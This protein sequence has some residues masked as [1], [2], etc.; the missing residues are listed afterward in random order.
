M[1]IQPSVTRYAALRKLLALSPATVAVTCSDISAVPESFYRADDPWPAYQ[2]LTYARS[3]GLPGLY[4]TWLWRALH[5]HSQCDPALDGARTAIISALV[6]YAAGN[7]SLKLCAMVNNRPAFDRCLFHLRTWYAGLGP[8]GQKFTERLQQLTKALNAGPEHW[9]QALNRF[10]QVCDKELARAA[11]LAERMQTSELGRIKIAHARRRVNDIYNEQVA[12]RQLP[13][14]ALEFI[15]HIVLPSLQYLLINESEQAPDWSFWLQVLRLIV[16]TVNPDKPPEDRQAFFNKGPALLSQLE[17]KAV[18]KAF[19][20]HVYHDYLDELSALIIS[21]LKGHEVDTITAPKRHISAELKSLSQLQS[22]AAKHHFCNGDW[23]EFDDGISLIRCQ[24]LMQVPNTDTLLFVNRSGH[25]VLQKTIAQMSVCFDAGIAQPI[26][27]TPGLSTALTTVAARME[28]MQEHLLTQARA[29]QTERQN[30]KQQQ[31][32]QQQAKNRLLQTRHEAE[33][34]ARQE[35]RRLALEH[36]AQQRAIKE[37]QA[38]QA[39][40][41]HEQQMRDTLDK[42]TLGTWA[43]L[44]LDNGKPVRCKLA[45]SMRSSNKYIFVDRVG[46]KI[47]ELLYDDLLGFLQRGEATFYQPEQPFESRLETIVRGLRRTE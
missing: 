25:K 21:L 17:T 43:D 2:Q 6:D 19:A 14:S 22:G 12:Q 46:Q 47:A 29:A 36:D 5:E 40:Q 10:N 27:T 28:N 42:L 3:A 45:V 33:L 30:L 23:L 7:E 31:Q 9:A 20:Q 13:E 41:A 1:A 4:A 35:A 18:S 26:P 8:T 38:S 24:F 44:P 34:K 16:W 32:A 11:L 39:R 37:R 15:D